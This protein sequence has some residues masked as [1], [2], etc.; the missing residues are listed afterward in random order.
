[1]KA[2][3]TKFEKSHSYTPGTKI[4]FGILIFLLP[5]SQAVSGNTGIPQKS[6]H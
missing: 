1:M 6:D 5:W 4:A 3:K 2:L